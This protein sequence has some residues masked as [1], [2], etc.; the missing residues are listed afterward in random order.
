MQA[1]V[2][3]EAHL[4]ALVCERARVGAGEPHRADWWRDVTH[5]SSSAVRGI[6][7]ADATTPQHGPAPSVGRRVHSVLSTL[8]QTEVRVRLVHEREGRVGCLVGKATS[9]KHDRVRT[10]RVLSMAAAELARVGGGLAW[11]CKTC[12]RD[13]KVVSTKMQLVK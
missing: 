12:E 1:H 4:E 11:N 2:V 5:N 10:E 13:D 8:H 6:K 9:T 7:P 3:E